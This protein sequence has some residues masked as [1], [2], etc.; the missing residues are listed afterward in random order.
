MQRRTSLDI[1]TCI[2]TV[3]HKGAKKTRIQYRCNLSHKQT[4]KHLNTLLESKLLET[5]SQTYV[6]TEKG[7]KFLKVYGEL[8]ELLK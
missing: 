5:Q 8:K 7:H 2:L 6:T 1:F 3:A 4:G